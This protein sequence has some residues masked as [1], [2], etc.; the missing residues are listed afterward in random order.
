MKNDDGCLL[1]LTAI[2]CSFVLGM[3]LATWVFPSVMLEA[4]KDEAVERGY[5]EY[6]IVDKKILFQ[7]KKPVDC[8][9]EATKEQHHEE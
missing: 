8:S 9:Q 2:L 3:A 4:C 6:V 7:W 5:A 1:P